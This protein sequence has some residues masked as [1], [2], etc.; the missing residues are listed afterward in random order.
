MGE[1]FMFL[2]SNTFCTTIVCTKLQSDPV[3]IFISEQAIYIIWIRTS[4]GS[5]FVHSDILNLLSNNYGNELNT[6][7]YVHFQKNNVLLFQY[8]TWK[9]RPYQ[10]KIVSLALCNKTGLEN[11][12]LASRVRI[13]TS[14]QILL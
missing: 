12:C 3:R 5:W 8:Y 9:F 2:I 14:S 7:V 10:V 1:I 4:M 13:P 6:F 11:G